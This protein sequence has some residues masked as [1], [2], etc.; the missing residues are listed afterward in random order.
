[1][2]N[3]LP[4]A[5]TICGERISTVI[6]A[7]ATAETGW[8]EYGTAT[9]DMTLFPLAKSWYMGANVPGKPR[10]CLPYVGGVAAYRRVCN[11]V[12]AQDYLGFRFDGPGGARCND[13]LIRRQQPDVVALLEMLADMEL[14]PFESMSPEQA[15]ADIG[16]DERWQSSGAGRR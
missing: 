12:A 14:P 7:T 3:G 13:G 6:D 2:S 1:M 10:V 9:S 15:R 11:D 4:I 16:G 8:V 5:W